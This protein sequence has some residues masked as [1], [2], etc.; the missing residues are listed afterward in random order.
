MFEFE[1]NQE[2]NDISLRIIAIFGNGHK[3]HEWLKCATLQDS[4]SQTYH[5]VLKQKTENFHQKFK[6]QFVNSIIFSACQLTA[7][8]L[9]NF[10][11]LLIWYL[12]KEETEKI[13]CNKWSQRID[14]IYG[15]HDAMVNNIIKR[16]KQRIN[17]KTAEK[18]LQRGKNCAEYFI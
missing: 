17:V 1:L 18:N 15:K 7:S 2:T 12:K 14:S 13:K 11:L 10:S 5:S 3:S 8:I 4:W 16:I 6:I 9:F